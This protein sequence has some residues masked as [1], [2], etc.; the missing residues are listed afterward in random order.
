MV[1]VP[2]RKIDVIDYLVDSR[3]ALGSILVTDAARVY[4]NI[5]TRLGIEH[6]SVNHRVNF[7][8]PTNTSININMIESRW[9]AVKQ[10]V[11]S[12][13][14]TNYVESCIAQYL[15]EFEHF[16]P[17]KEKFSYG[18][19]FEKQVSDIVRVYV[20][21]DPNKIPLELIVDDWNQILR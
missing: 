13:K 14:N 12:Y 6:E 16:Y 5:Q 21:P 10:K 19:S 17:L 15:Y 3:I 1:R 9:A 8:S 11:K 2:N 7:V 20:G 18:K 4:V